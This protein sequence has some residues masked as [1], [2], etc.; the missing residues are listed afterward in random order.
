LAGLARAGLANQEAGVNAA[1]PALAAQGWG[2]SK[3][4]DLAR[5]QYAIPL[6]NLAQISGIAD[7]IAAQFASTSSNG[8]ATSQTHVPAWQQILGRARGPAGTAWRSPAS[9][10]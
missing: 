4:L 3:P 6:Q 2:P 7:P 8:T 10:A 9:E 1:D 5:Q